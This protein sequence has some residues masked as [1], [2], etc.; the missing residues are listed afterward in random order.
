LY[1]AAIDNVTVRNVVRPAAAGGGEGPGFIRAGGG[2]PEPWTRDASINSW[3]AASVLV[4]DVARETLFAVCSRGAGERVVAQDNQWWDQIV[5]VVA[6]WHHYLV[7]GDRVFLVEAVGI[8]ERSLAIL[9]SARFDEEFGLF[10]GPAVMQDGISGYPMSLTEPGNGSSFVLDHPRMPHAMTLSTNALYVG[11]LR[12]LGWMTAELGGDGTGFERQ[13]AELAEV[14]R[15]RFRIPGTGRYGFLIH[16]AGPERGTL[17]EQQEGCGLAFLAL[18]A[19]GAPAAARAVLA[20]VQR[21]PFGV[22]N[23][24]P[25]MPPGS[26]EKPARHGGILWPMVMGMVGAAAAGARDIR[27][28]RQS[29]RDLE[30]LFSGSGGELFEVY[31]GSTGVVDG[32]WQ[33]GVHW[34]SE[35]DQTW[36]ASAY[37]RLIH[38]GVFGLRHGT[39]GLGFAP[40]V[41]VEFAGAVLEGLRYR[42]AS[43]TV[44]LE[45]HGDDLAGILVDGRD[46]GAGWVLPA[47]ST[48]HH[49]VHLILRTPTD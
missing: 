9:R 13:A 12:A 11:A 28:L 29:I 14:V 46:Q 48:G 43:L 20:E 33:C 35:P 24:W 37:L 3:N 36:S 8:A 5:W 26:A 21:L 38:E 16:G 44:T 49:E 1:A 34:D 23:V 31:N 42:D 41:P 27:L 2:Y 47:T 7:T 19:A 10:V 22:P 39:A 40:L 4:P 6:A 25:H 32:G 45:G 18:F 15:S 30:T 17:E